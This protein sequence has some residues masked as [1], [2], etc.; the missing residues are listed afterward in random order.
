MAYILGIVVVALFFLALHSFTELNHK[1]KSV[2]TA[3]FLAIIGGAVY[4]NTL[5]DAERE[6][7][8][9]VQQQY[10]QGKTIMC[11]GIEVNATNFSFSIGTRTFI[12]KKNTPH[13]TRMINAA[14]C[15]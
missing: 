7:I 10:D 13:Y 4:Y 11:D 8:I 15:Q 3:I 5:Q 2:I 1:Q 9:Y 6:R 12:G 14:Q